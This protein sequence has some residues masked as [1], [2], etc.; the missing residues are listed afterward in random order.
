[1]TTMETRTT[2]KTNNLSCAE[3]IKL[4]RRALTRSPFCVNTEEGFCVQMTV[5]AY[6]KINWSLDIVNRRDDGYH[7]MNMLMQNVDLC[8]EISFAP[9]R[10]VTLEMNGRMIASGSKN[11]IVRAATALNEYMGENHGMRIQLKKRIPVRAGLGGGSA[12]CAAA[13]L[14][15]NELWHMRLPLKTLLSIGEKLGADVP[16]CLTGGYARVSGIGE[17]LTPKDGAPSFPLLITL[18]GEGLN[19]Q[20]VFSAFDGGGFEKLGVDV[21]ALAFALSNGDLTSAQ[22]L[23]GNA[24]EGPAIGLLPEIAT[25]MDRMREGGAKFVR[26][27]GSGSA[28]YG[29][30]ET[31]EAA[32]RAKPLFSNAILTRT[33]PGK[34]N[35]LSAI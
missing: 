14:A 5:K 17:V 1:M 10:F 26:M 24:L 12:D 33:M 2:R 28:V 34:G 19:T 27:S 35:V 3:G 16:Y 31:E 21:D 8:D 22:R 7:E 25:V 32:I 9:A 23:S 4:K 11:L 29:V 20:T 15:L 13:L 30:F 18:V 6:A